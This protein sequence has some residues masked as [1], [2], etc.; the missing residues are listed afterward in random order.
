M[1]NPSAVSLLV[2]LKSREIRKQRLV[3]SIC[4]SFGTTPPEHFLQPL[5]RRLDFRHQFLQLISVLRHRFGRIHE[6]AK[7]SLHDGELRLKSLDLLLNS[8]VVVLPL[9]IALTLLI[10]LLL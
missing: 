4:A 7:V 5:V 3:E 1:N 8:S 6:R 10:E 9:L 2:I